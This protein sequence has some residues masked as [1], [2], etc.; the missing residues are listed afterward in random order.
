MD[1]TPIYQLQ[2][3]TPFSPFAG[4]SVRTRGVVT[5]AVKH[6]FFIQDPDAG[7]YGADAQGCS[8]ALFVFSRGRK[9]AVGNWLELDAK[10]IDYTRLEIDKPVTQLQMNKVR[11]LQRNGPEIVPYMLRAAALPAEATEQAQYLNSLEGM[12]VGIEAGATFVQASNP[13]GDY[14]VVPLDWEEHADRF[15]ALRSAEGGV[16]LG[17]NKQSL[18]LPGFRIRKS[19]DA[20]KI[21]VGARLQTPVA[22]PM[23]Y[24]VGA[25]QI[26]VT[27]SFDATQADIDISAST[28]VP[29]AN[30]LS[31]LTLNTFNLDPH[32]ERARF[33]ADPRSDIDDDI[34]SGQYRLL[35]E[36]VVQQAA[37]PDIVALQEIQDSDGA[38]ITQTVSAHK[39]LKRICADIERAGGPTYAWVDLPPESGADGGQPGGNIR[40]AF[41]YNPAR[42]LLREG[43]AIRLGEN[44]PAF[45]D[46]R[47]P[48]IA[49]FA[50]QHNGT[51][52]S[53]WLTV[54]NL[55]LAS[56][57]KQH[58]IFAVQDPGHDPRAAMRV[59][60]AALVRQHL[61]ALLN[62]DQEFYV[63]GDFND[64]EH[65][66]TLRTMLG[67]D[68][69]NMLERLPARQR[70][71][72]NHRG[73][74]HALMHGVVPL[75]MQQQNRVEYEVLHGNELL[76]VRP[77]ELD[78]AQKASDHAYVIARIQPGSA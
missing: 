36:A 28:L 46:S 71:D 8:H 20:P 59:A 41:L 78:R 48:S 60:Q 67:E 6:G 39:T 43:S 32:I 9:P 1:N 18:W 3:P 44:D 68:C 72:Y 30:A 69:C 27:G 10:V 31:V 70:Y 4:Q 45:T 58:S 19:R 50:L 2:G 40:N 16:L 38:E 35:A 62:S 53:A 42:T 74:L 22:G 77:G 15:D 24:R 37:C 23:D 63:T 49:E 55:H 75:E 34:G 56:K 33:V 64:V 21:N 66:Q 52:S 26:A 54:V 14:V 47:K 73:K 61:Q 17:P 29:T 13:F 7:T 57:R 11:L 65:S 76:G 5:G 12:L 25:Y 51:R